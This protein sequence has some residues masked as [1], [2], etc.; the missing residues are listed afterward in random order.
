MLDFLGSD[1]FNFIFCD[2]DPLISANETICDAKHWTKMWSK[3]PNSSP[4]DHQISGD[5]YFRF[6]HLKINQV[7][8]P[9]QEV[10]LLMENSEILF[11]LQ[12]WSPQNT[13]PPPPARIETS[14]WK[15]WHCRDFALLEGYGL[16]HTFNS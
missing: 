6:G 8:T 9:T 2:K 5:F 3:I 11:G 10:N 14:Y 1:L 7:P 12:I 15:L 16:I 4:N 13:P